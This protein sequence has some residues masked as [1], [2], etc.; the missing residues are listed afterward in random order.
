MDMHAKDGLK[1][2]DEPTNWIETN[3]LYSIPY[4]SLYSRNISNLFV[5]GRNI[6][7]SHMAFGSTRIMATCGTVGQAIGTA[8][9]MTIEKGINP[10]QV[11]EHIA[12]L[13]RRLIRDDCYLFGHKDRDSANYALKAKATASSYLP[14]FDADK[15][16]N[17]IQ[18][19]I[20][21]ENN[22]WISKPLQQEPAVLTLA[23][24]K[25]IQAREVIINFDS[26]LSAE[27]M[28]T[29]SKPNKAKQREGF[30]PEIVKNYRL[31]FYFQDSL[32][33]SKS[34]EANHQRHNK[35]QLTSPVICDRIELTCI[36][37]HGDP[38]ARVFEVKV[39]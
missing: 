8:A 14:G 25:A 37:T 18:R 26:N 2:K 5:G 34:V 30:P 38:C 31:D 17:G 3:D 19:N 1:S 21:T 7:A 22:L 10:R 28:I 36:E 24:E 4:R 12:E 16:V 33:F 39:F 27:I 11:L 13:Q 15:V 20:G 29:I 32:I 35:L 9:A 23:F 6:S